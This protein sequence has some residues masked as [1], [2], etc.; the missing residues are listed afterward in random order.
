MA[1]SIT[2]VVCTYN[3]ESTIQLVLDS[4]A[5]LTYKPLEVIVINDASTDHTAE[6]VSKYAVRQIENPKNMG[7]G[8]NQ[9]LGLSL[10]KSEYMV[11]LQSDCEILQNDWL[12]QM[13]QLMTDDVA[14]V[15][16]QREIHKFAELSAGAR[17]FNAVAP[18]DLLN[19]TNKSID[20][21]YCRGKADLY[22]VSIL[23][24]IGGW[25]RDFFTAGEDTD[26]SIKIRKLGHR[27]V[28][29]P[30]AKVKY[31]FSGRQVSITGGLTKAFLYG[32]VAYPLYKLHRYDGIQS[33]TY[34]HM[35]LAAIVWLLP[36]PFDGILG[37]LILANSFTCSISST[38]VRG[39]SFGVLSLIACVPFVMLNSPH[40]LRGVM[41]SIPA[42]ILLAG[43]AYTGYLAAKNT[44]RN[45]GKGEKLHRL[46]GTFLFCIAWRLVSGIGY[47]AGAMKGFS[48][49][50]KKTLENHANPID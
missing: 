42:G 27:I 37:A 11:L 8:Y 36:F 39:V 44:F 29:H 32:S 43:S 41:Q 38:A 9:N 6:I 40:G 13:I 30:T 50:R 10:T 19:A 25:D 46:P 31:L 16:S 22:R 35:I 26:L 34:A 20:Q 12:E 23:R 2:L 47:L 48:K 4:I 3:D 15:V 1:S 5:R 28:L 21:Q 45:Y 7:L 24:E 14:V 18:Q 17:L 49:N 33:R